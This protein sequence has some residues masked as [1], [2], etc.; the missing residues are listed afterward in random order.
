MNQEMQ[1]YAERPPV[2]KVLLWLV[3]PF[4]LGL[5]LFSRPAGYCRAE[6]RV[7]AKE[8]LCE[9]LLEKS[10][11]EG[12]VRLTGGDRTARDFL[13]RQSNACH[14]DTS[15]MVRFRSYGLVDAMFSD[16][17]YVS[18]HYSMTDKAKSLRRLSG[19]AIWSELLEVSPCG[20]VRHASGG[21]Y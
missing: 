8:E 15:A 9:K 10:L 4:I 21:N 16:T 14:V 11:S 13:A 17:V 6:A 12:W 20:D 2:G 5:F 1:G 7:L 3:L 19:D 18:I